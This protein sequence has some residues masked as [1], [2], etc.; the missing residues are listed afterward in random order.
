M[1]GTTSTLDKVTG[2]GA[3]EDD[4]SRSVTVPTAVM[5]SRSLFATATVLRGGL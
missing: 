3:P 1:P 5:G 4:V 2:I